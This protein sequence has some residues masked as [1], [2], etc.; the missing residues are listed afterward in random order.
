[1]FAVYL[2][3]YVYL[4]DY[5]IN[6]G[7]NETVLINKLNGDGVKFFG[8]KWRSLKRD[9]VEDADE[10]VQLVFFYFFFKKNYFIL[11]KI[12]LGIIYINNMSFIAEDGI[13]IIKP[14]NE[15]T[16]EILAVK[17]GRANCS[18]FIKDSVEN[19]PTV[20]ICDFAKENVK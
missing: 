6:N 19:I 14:I 12:L 10:I 17:K 9:E 16:H 13:S 4:L 1:M 2:L 8:K 11:K 18:K 15:F 5:S 3:S 20:V 7:E